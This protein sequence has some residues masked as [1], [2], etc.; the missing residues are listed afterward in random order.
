MGAALFPRRPSSEQFSI[1][2]RRQTVIA[3]I[4]SLNIEQAGIFFCQANPLGLGG[5][6]A[7]GL[8][9]LTLDPGNGGIV[10]LE[11]LQQPSIGASSA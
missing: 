5:R 3:I 6:K 9:Q 8:W 10:S 1:G 11:A 4:E 7:R 2:C